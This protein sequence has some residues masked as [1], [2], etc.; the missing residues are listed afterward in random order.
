MCA[1]ALPAAPAANPGYRAAVPRPGPGPYIPDGNLAIRDPHSPSANG[2]GV[3]PGGL[4]AYGQLR[5]NA[6][7]Q[8][9]S[10]RI[11][12]EQVLDDLRDAA[13]LDGLMPGRAGRAGC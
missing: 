1:R 7:G 8:R 12:R 5:V 6:R 11:G 9:V 10:G 4:G 3:I 2:I 13:D